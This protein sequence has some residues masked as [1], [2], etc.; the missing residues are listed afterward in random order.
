MLQIIVGRLKLL[1]CVFVVQIQ[2]AATIDV[3]S[4]YDLSPQTMHPVYA[5][6]WLNKKQ[7]SIG[8][9]IFAPPLTGNAQFNHQL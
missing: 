5:R 7:Y 9:E 3:T 2:T 8:S 6:A 4:A 1:D